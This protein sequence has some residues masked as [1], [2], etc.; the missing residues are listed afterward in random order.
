MKKP[1]LFGR[2]WI[3]A[4]SLISVIWVSCNKKC[5]NLN[6][7]IAG[8]VLREYDFGDCKVYAR[9]DSHLVISNQSEWDSY[10]N[11]KLKV[12]DNGNL[13]AIDFNAEALIGYKISQIACNVGFKKTITVDAVNKEYIYTV[14]LD[15]CT[16]C[17]TEI[18]S[19]NWVVGP[20]IPPDYKV[21]FQTK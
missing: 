20:K 3:I 17:N 15:K 14:T 8:S 18:T 16:G 2:I 10:R 21:I 4:L 19:H 6:G 1:I 11:A 12:C 9:V 7:G 13:P 5:A